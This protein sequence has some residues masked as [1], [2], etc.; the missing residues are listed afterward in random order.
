[1]TP[2]SFVTPKRLAA[3]LHVTTRYF[4]VTAAR[5]HNLLN[6][7][8]CAVRCRH[9]AEDSERSTWRCKPTERD[10]PETWVAILFYLRKQYALLLRT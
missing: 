3:W 7:A 9:H 10:T 4:W 5:E 2:C 6:I 8:C 1:M